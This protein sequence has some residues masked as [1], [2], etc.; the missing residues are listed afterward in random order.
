MF[1]LENV[2][3]FILIAV[4]AL[5]SFTLVESVI[6]ERG[7]VG[8]V[9]AASDSIVYENIVGSDNNVTNMV[10]FDEGT[11]EDLSAQMNADGWQEFRSEGYA[12][13][14]SY[15]PQIL[16]NGIPDQKSLNAGLEV[17]EGTPV[18]QFYMADPALFEGTNLVEASIV[19]QVSRGEGALAA[20]LSYKSGSIYQLSGE[21]LPSLEINQVSFLKDVVQEGVMGGSY[22][23]ISYRALS[24]G[25]CY[26]LTQVV[27][28][29]NLENF[30]ANTILPFDE[31]SI[32]AQLDQVLATFKFLDTE[33]TFPDM[34]YP[35][36]KSVNLTVDKAVGGYADGIDV[37]HWQG[38][39]KWAKVGEAGY[40]FAFVKGTEGVGWTDVLFHENMTNGPDS[41]VVRGVYHFARPDLGNTGREEA[42][43][44][45]SVAG[46]YLK[47]G[48]L[49]PVLDLEVRGSLGQTALSAWVLEWMQTVENQSGVA[50]L[51]YTNLNYVNNYLT[52]AVTEYDLW[53][54]YWTWGCNPTVT[55]TIP[56]TGR[57]SDWAFWQYCVAPGGT[58]PGISTAIDLDIF[59]GVEES[60]IEYDAASPLWVSLTS[61]VYRA[62]KPYFADITADVNGD[63]TG[64]INYYFWWNCN[65]LEADI[66][67]AEAACGVLPQPAP[68][69][70]L[71]DGVGM[72]CDAVANEVQLAEYTYQE[73]GDFTAKVIVERGTAAPAEDRYQISIVN[74]LLSLS[75]DPVSP[76]I[77]TPYKDYAVG[78]D[79]VVKPSVNGVVQVEIIENGSLTPLDSFCQEVVGD[80]QSSEAF[81]MTI[82]WSTGE[83]LTYEI[84]ARYRSDVIC[85]VT[86]NDPDDLSLS[87]EIDWNQPTFSDVPFDHPFHAYIQALWDAGF[88]AG[89]SIDPLMFC[90]DMVMDRAQSAVFMLRGQFGTVYVPPLE[91]WDTFMDDW[92]LSD[93]SWA[94]KWAEGM[95]EEGLTAGCLADPLLY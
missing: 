89:C 64:L 16:L 63:A 67:S 33:A 48:Y 39:V 56:P 95:W 73:I 32:F 60:L 55:F 7:F 74:P 91:P 35:E 77:G 20:C 37:S 22:K 84:W 44:F 38:D 14:L 87:Y 10:V 54:A 86:D 59:N 45:L 93:I 62:P 82:P 26:E 23:R 28:S 36:A 50:P 58:V 13:E 71:N 53:I 2:L 18:W 79:V 49:R 76:G 57:W 75:T 27:H 92:S 24:Q 40:T 42:E 30:Q 21:G 25:A 34:V 69:E 85:P 11:A 51:I 80:V 31:Q 41:G 68:G 6:G 5:V 19:V 90:P 15:P 52:N 81:D 94:E 46:D 78:V 72:R 4:C 8:T 29:K 88:T 12:F 43:Y 17:P 65:S 47:S 9:L 3:L 70:C 1:K 61:D 83:I 66:T